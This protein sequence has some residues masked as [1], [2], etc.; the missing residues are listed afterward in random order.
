MVFSKC[1]P[2]TTAFYYLITIIMAVATKNPVILMLFLVATIVHFALEYRLRKLGEKIAYYVIV[3]T[4]LLLLSAAFKHNGVTPLFFWNEQAVTKETLFWS[5]ML[6]VLFLF[7]SSLY[8]NFTKNLPLNKMLYLCRRVSPTLSMYSS[9][10]ILLVGSYKL[11][12]KQVHAAQK[13]I[14]YYATASFFDQIS[15]LLKTS[16]E[17]AVWAMEQCMHK[18]ECMKSRGYYL[19]NKTVFVFYKWHKIDTFLLIL[20][21]GLFI[22][23]LTFYPQTRFFYFPHTKELDIPSVMLYSCSTVAIIPLLIEWKE[24][25]TWHYYNLKM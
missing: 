22:V 13:S 18:S 1:H 11:R 14:G 15:G 16:Y 12:W 21:S 25:I 10:V 20:M 19:K 17:C 2:F 7:L 5:C 23:F 8:Q 9:L 24:R 3:A 6:G 4:I